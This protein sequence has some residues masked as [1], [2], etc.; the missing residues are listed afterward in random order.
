[1][2]KSLLSAKNPLLIIAVGSVY[3]IVSNLYEIIFQHIYDPFEILIILVS[4]LFIYFYIKKPKYA[5]HIMFFGLLSLWPVYYILMALGLKTPPKYTGVYYIMG[6]VYIIL[7]IF[8]W[9]LKKM[10]VKYFS[11][12]N[13]E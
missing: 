11:E 8:L 1:M 4:S 10:Y 13:P 7:G 5:G 3:S 2:K 6:V 9:K 12:N